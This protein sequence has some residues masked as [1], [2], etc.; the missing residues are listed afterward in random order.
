VAD[1]VFVWGKLIGA[2][3]RSQLQY[4]T[5]FVLDVLGTFWLS[6]IDFLVVLTIFH[7]V[8]RLGSWS[9]HEVAFL[10]GLSAMTFA[11]TDMAI[12]Q[13]DQFPQRIREG[14][15]DI[16]LVRPRGTLF[17]VVAS[18]FAT[19]R[20]ARVLQGAIVFVYA[21]SGLTIHWTVP[22]VLVLLISLPSA[23]LIFS[24]IWVVGACIAFWTTDG[25]EFTNAFTYGG[26]AMTQYPL[27][28]YGAWL[29]RLLGFVIPLAFV[30]YFPALYILGKYDPLGL[31]RFLEFCSPLV[32]VTSAC[33]AGSVWR[34]AVR[35]Y[36]SAGG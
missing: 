35:H 34:F 19:R 17:Q 36:R 13:L 9:V 20:L 5:S 33:V 3:I 28:I 30:C 24:S 10:Y 11:F 12:G 29:R 14:S 25:G 6:F 18:D 7:N 1:A 16:V 27:D 32:A 8:P 4:R 21:L 23:I 15:F 31:P 22:R 2:Q 26:T